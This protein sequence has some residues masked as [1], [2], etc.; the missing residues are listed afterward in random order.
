MLS[1]A[2]G[3]Y[4]LAAGAVGELLPIF[5]I[6]V[7]LSA[8]GSFVALLSLVAMGL[9]AYGL[10]VIPRIRRGQRHPPHHP[11]KA[12]TPPHRPRCAGRSSSWSCCS[13][14]RARSVLDV[15][16][17]AFVAGAVLRRAAPGDMHSLE[18]KLEAVGYGFFIPLFF[19]GSG[20][21]L[22]IKSIAHS[23][24]RLV[25][26]FLLLL[27]VRGLPSLLVY[28]HVLGTRHRVEMT[29]LTATSL[30]LM[31]GA[32]R[33]RAAGR[34]HAPRQRRRPGRRRRALRRGVPDA[35]GRDQ[36]TWAAPS[37]RSGPARRPETWRTGEGSMAG[38]T[39]AVRVPTSQA[40]DPTR[41]IP[42][43]RPVWI[44]ADHAGTEHLVQ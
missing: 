2:F 12:S 26:F 6:S 13:P 11:G 8:H 9:L 44:V 32:E 33:D 5:A 22:N 15:V 38:W 23:P 39:A 16:L 21:N 36:E 17:G 10:S 41:R 3:P 40:V 43:D 34:H 37:K 35:G 30:P 25:V 24:A 18:G 28:A 31:V 20:M 27:V 42:H 4:I 14:S 19:V 7:F 29:L 1:G